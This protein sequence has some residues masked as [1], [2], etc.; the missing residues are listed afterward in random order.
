MR[1]A[2]F[3][4][5]GLADV[6]CAVPALR[7]LDAAYPQARITLIGLPSSTPTAQLFTDLGQTLREARQLLDR[8]SSAGI[9]PAG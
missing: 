4:P 5:L 6:L 3:R 8:S 1:I 2:L 9:G 7:A